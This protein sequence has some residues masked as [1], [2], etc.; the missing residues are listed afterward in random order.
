MPNKSKKNLSQKRGRF[1]FCAAESALSV[2]ARH[3][4]Q[5]EIQVW[6]VRKTKAFLP[7]EGGTAQAVTEG[8]ARWWVCIRANLMRICQ[9]V[10]LPQSLPAAN[11]APSKR[12]PALSVAARHLS[13]RERQGGLREPKAFLPEEGGTAQAVTEG[14]AHGQVCIRAN[15]MRILPICKTPSVLPQG[16]NPAPSKREP[17]LSVAPR[18]LSQRER[19]GGL[20]GKPKPSSLRKV[21]RRKP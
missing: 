10:K 5:R 2:A 4:S 19:Q 16:G 7:E 8:A 18:H 13:Q 3:L 17:A 14:A 9:F 1:F 15:L 21:A 6:T 11:P 20:C 12:E